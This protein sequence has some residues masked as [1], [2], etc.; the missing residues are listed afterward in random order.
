MSLDNENIISS[1]RSVDFY[2]DYEEFSDLNFRKFVIILNQNI[3]PVII[4]TTLSFLIALTIFLKTPLKY[5]A[6]AV[7]L[8]VSGRTTSGLNLESFGAS[9]LL[10]IL[11]SGQIPSANSHEK[12]LITSHLSSYKLHNQILMKHDLVGEF[13]EKS[14]SKY[15]AEDYQEATYELMKLFLLD[16]LRTTWGKILFY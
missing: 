10:E 3:I 15:S 12:N 7:I 9:S 5:E 16:V 6:E 11:S 1:K 8:P 4:F 14:N 2:N 13:V